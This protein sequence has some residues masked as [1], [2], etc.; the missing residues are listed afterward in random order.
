MESRYSNS[1]RNILT[2]IGTKLLLTALAFISRTVFIR[3]L[4]VEYNGINSLYANILSI[5][6]F[7][8]LGI[9]NVLTFSLYAAFKEKDYQKI[10]SLIHYFK[11]IY[12]G[13]SCIILMMG[14]MLIPLLAYIVNSSLPY[15]QILI[16]YILYLANTV[17]SYLLIYKQNVIVADQKGYIN[18]ICDAVA[19]LLMYILQITSLLINRNFTIYL[20]IQLGYTLGKN[21]LIHAVSNRMYPYLKDKC[22]SIGNAE[23]K[24]LI[25]NIKSTFIYKISERML[26]NTDNILISAIVGTAYVGFYSNYYTIVMYV[27]AIIGIFINGF[28]ASLGNL[29]AEK[30]QELS[31]RIFNVC[32]LIF[33]FVGAVLACCFMNCLQPFVKIWIGDQ[34]IVPFV[35]VA[36][37][38]FNNYVDEIMNPVW[39]FR[40]TMGLFQQVKYLMLIAAVLNLILSVILGIKWGVPGILLATVVSKLATQYWYEPRLLYR[41]RFHQPLKTFYLIVFKNVVACALAIVLSLWVCSYLGN[42]LPEIVLRATV[43]GIIAVVC[44]WLVH[45]RS[46]AWNDLWFRYIVPFIRR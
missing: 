24:L 34:Y 20:L 9:S 32:M 4:G 21:I 40:E 35:W 28:M 13:V 22:V 26:N 44:M 7:S 27:V 3:E 8:E 15:H 6:S 31:F 45:F 25:Q 11:K 43:A 19:S 14:L 30:D 29:N 12:Y 39:I 2:G 33:G 17:V 1:I 23:K 16:Y 18:S 41:Q 46:E 38:I 10:N 36:V 37:I 42:S 5:L